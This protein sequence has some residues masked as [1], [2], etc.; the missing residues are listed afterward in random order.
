MA[1]VPLVQ[2]TT[3]LLTASGSALLDLPEVRSTLDL[4][5]PVA[6]SAVALLHFLPGPPGPQLIRDI[7]DRLAPGSML[8]L[9][10]LTADF[11]PE[12]VTP[13]VEQYARTVAPLCTRTYTEIQQIFHG[14]EILD[15]GIVPASDWRPGHDDTQPAR[16]QINCWA[17]VGRLP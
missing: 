13:G 11:A 10:H 1:Y 17:A 12:M 15:P 3:A 16:D 6:L 14:L 8:V 5:Q 9:S 4:T 7:L 2:R